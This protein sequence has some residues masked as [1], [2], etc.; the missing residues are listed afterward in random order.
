MRTVARLLFVAFAIVPLSPTGCDKAASVDQTADFELQLATVEAPSGAGASDVPDASPHGLPGDA[1]SSQQEI[2]S[3]WLT[4]SNVRCRKGYRCVMG[5]SRPQ[6]LLGHAP[7]PGCVPVPRCMRDPISC[8]CPQIWKPVCA[9]DNG[10]Y[11]NEC[12]ARCVG[13]EPL[14][15]GACT[16]DACATVLCRP[17]TFC[18]SGVCRPV[19]THSGPD[20]S[21]G[22]GATP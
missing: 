11:P 16:H 4:C 19:S 10:T 20:A 13:A 5:C 3:R 15:A 12:T 21:G 7:K 18:E 2:E 14:H 9:S 17:G 22:K 1:G 8:A 6:P